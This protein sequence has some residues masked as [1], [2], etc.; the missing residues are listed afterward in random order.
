MTST[1]VHALA[2]AVLET[3][4]T[5]GLMIATAESCTGGLIAGALTEI[6][7][8][9]DV[10]ERGF[11]TYSNEAKQTLLGVPTGLLDSVG[12]VSEEVARAMAEA[13]WRGRERNWPS[14]SP[15]LP[16]P[17]GEP[18]P[19]PWDWFIWLLPARAWKRRISGMSFRAIGP[20][21]GPRRWLRRC[22]A[23]VWL[24]LVRSRRL[25]GGSRL[26]RA[27]RRP[28]SVMKSA[29]SKSPNSFLALVS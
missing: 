3:C 18:R 28:S 2:T 6:A 12:A 16:V 5:A 21:C 4:R 22:S 10:V 11:V 23:F 24:L 8:S 19:N 25:A 7:G 20:R 17:A 14:L 15:G 29:F 9:S 27:S 1:D 26:A 13:L